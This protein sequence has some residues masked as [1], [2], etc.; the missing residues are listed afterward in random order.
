MAGFAA[1]AI[2]KL[3]ALAAHLACNRIGMAIKADLGRC[4][5][6]DAEFARNRLRRIAAQRLPRLGMRIEF[7][8]DG[9]FVLLDIG[10]AKRLR[11]AVADAVAATG[12]AKVLVRFN[13]T[14]R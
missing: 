8:P 11:C 5:V 14:D 2:G 6:A 9:E 7:L 4:R 3:E 12:H 1:H 13:R 10:F